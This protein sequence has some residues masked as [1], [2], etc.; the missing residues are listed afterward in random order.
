MRLLPTPR[1]PVRSARRLWRRLLAS[2]FVCA[3]PVLLAAP[4]SA[5]EI[6]WV[7]VGDPGNPPDTASNCFAA[8]CGS[9]GYEYSISKFEV[10]N[11]QYAEF[12][13]LKAARN[14]VG[15]YNT[16]MGSDA[17]GGITRSGSPGS[18]TYAVKPG[19][20]DKPVNFVSLYDA[21]RFANWL[22]NGQG[23][24]D[25]ESGAYTL[26][27]GTALP[28]NWSTVTS[29][30]DAKIFLPSENEWYKAAYYDGPSATYFVFPT[31]TDAPT[32]CSAPTEAANGANCQ[33]EASGLTDVGA[34]TASASP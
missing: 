2:A 29:E 25:T 7:F 30:P 4:A 22:H 34:Y 8:N 26:L 31:G 28:S 10:T 9:V 13:N 3:L 15:L 1:V 33:R 17:Q 19:F 18:H 21:M 12:L 24:G 11:A 14:S 27:G 5:V 6:D 16:N 32:S 23:N 20:A